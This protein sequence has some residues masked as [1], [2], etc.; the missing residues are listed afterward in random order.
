MIVGKVLSLE[1][2]VIGGRSILRS[3][4]RQEVERYEVSE[5]WSH[6]LE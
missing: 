5:K 6:I 3:V 1:H 4:G 2:Y